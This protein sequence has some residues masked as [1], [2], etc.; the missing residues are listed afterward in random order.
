V[1][2]TEQQDAIREMARRFARERLRPGYQQREA[3][4]VIDRKLLKEM[5]QLGLIGVELPATDGGMDAGAVVAG[6]VSEEIAY[7]DFN[8]G[9]VQMMGSLL[10]GLV[11]RHA[12]PEIAKSWTR[13]QLAG[14][15]ILGIAVTEPQAGTDAANIQLAARTDGGG[16]DGYV[17]SGEKTSI[18]FCDQADALIVLARTGDQG[19]GAP[20][21]GA[22]G[23]TA[24]LVPTDLAGLTTRRFDDLGHKIVG[25]GSVFFDAVRVPATLR[26]GAE[27]TGFTQVMQGF[28]YSRILLSLMCL[29]A[30]QASI[31]ETWP[32][33]RERTSMG[34]PIA[35]YQGV[36][37]PLA[38]AESRI[39]A[40]RALCYH[41][42]ALRDAGRPYRV[43]SAMVKS[44]APKTALDAIQQ[45]IATIGHAAVS[46]DLAHQQRLRDVL[47]F[48][49]GEGTAEAMKLI[50]AR[51]RTGRV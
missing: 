46:M 17:L 3:T 41:G 20:N 21:G 7:G 24:F 16:H 1:V 48:Q 5:G 40:C 35:S 44:L 37:F 4:G 8:I 32:Y 31:D 12:R 38:E 50:I 19:T 13:R 36:T 27:G 6:L 2:F 49:F 28:E 23:V 45:C 11:S 51:E 15:V 43:E 34:A 29:A 30:A 39:A 14:E 47:G 33:T 22:K 18:S 9:C 25:R 42:L 26:L 10:G